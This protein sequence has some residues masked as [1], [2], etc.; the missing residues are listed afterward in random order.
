MQAPCCCNP[1]AL[2]RAAVFSRGLGLAHIQAE[3]TQLL[4]VID[5]KGKVVYRVQLPQEG[6]IIFLG[7]EPSGAALAAVQ[8]HGGAFLWFPSK[9]D[10]VQQWEG[11]QFASQLLRSSALK[12]NA[13]FDTCFASWSEARK[14]VLGLAVSGAEERR[15]EREERREQ[16]REH[17]R[18]RH[19]A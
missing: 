11:M 17:R 3:H 14:L 1:L 10:C 8:D 2:F 13:H 19:A 4:K 9:P 15:E 16:R 18:M 5:E 7:W 12:R 6:R